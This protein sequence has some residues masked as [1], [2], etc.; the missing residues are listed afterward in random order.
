MGRPIEQHRRWAWPAAAALALALAVLVRLRSS[1]PLWLDEALSVNIARLPLTELPAALRQDGAPPLYYLLL[2]GWIELF[3]TGTTQVR[4]LSTLLA[5]TALPL[6]YLVGRRLR[7]AS[8]GWACA[9]LFGAL[10]FLVRYATETRMYALAVVL[11]LLGVLAVERAWREPTARRLAAVSA[12][13]GLLLLT[14]YW[15]LYLLAVVGAL[16]LVLA[17]RGRRP[18]LRLAVA[19]AGGGVL[20]LP[21]L[22]SFL[23]Q[24]RHTGTP[25][26]RPPKPVALIDTLDTW[27][28]GRTLAGGVLGVLLVL[29]VVLAL[30]GR[31]SEDGVLLT[32][33]VDPVAGVLALA[34]IGT[35][36]LGIALARITSAG[37]APRYSSV[38]LVPFLLAA[39][40]GVS[41]LPRRARLAVLAVAVTCGLAGSAQIPLSH[42]RTQAAKLAAPIRAGLQPGD[43]VVYCPDQNG[44][45]VSR[46]LP[47][48]TDQVVYPTLGGP[49]RVDW[50][51]YA[52]RNA[53]ASPE[54]FAAD[55]LA[56]SDGA[57]WYVWRG[58]HR[59]FGTQCE[60]LGAA[61]ARSRGEGELVMEKRE[62]YGERANLTRYA[63]AT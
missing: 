23:F 31:R 53:A 13:A 5:L 10:P 56:R 19:L 14:H 26:A 22:P 27:T 8:T 15:A 55:V 49:E 32:R 48:G 18:A 43:L 12:V 58:G 45:A 2:H 29:L 33:R 61:L 24:A 35:L 38:A 59:T 11:V 21:W 39:G 46:L 30:L 17:L 52:E 25:W 28:G 62:S 4:L 60:D 1:S 51:D 40:L 20:F 6:A 37:Y 36:L 16:L 34:G 50:R 3:G 57:I 42:K 54:R 7:D 47:A 44:P 63:P 9:L 41:V